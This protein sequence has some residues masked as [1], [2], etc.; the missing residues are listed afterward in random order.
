MERVWDRLKLHDSTGETLPS[1]S[2]I[3]DR[4]HHPSGN[5]YGE[6]VRNRLGWT[7]I[8]TLTATSSTTAAEIV[9]DLTLPPPY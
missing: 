8:V 3:M 9:N 4:Y 2:D 6:D 7:G 1:A 5:T